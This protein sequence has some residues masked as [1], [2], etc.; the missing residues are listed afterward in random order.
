[1]ANCFFCQV[2]L[3]LEK[4]IGSLC[5]DGAPAMLRKKAGFVSLVN[6]EAPHIIVSHWFLIRHAVPPKPQPTPLKFCLLV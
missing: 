4:R 5:A 3:Q 1:M 2:N 6:K